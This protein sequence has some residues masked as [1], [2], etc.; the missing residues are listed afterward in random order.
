M[1]RR[2]VDV[3]AG[4]VL[5][6]FGIAF[7]DAGGRHIIRS[8]FE[9][10]YIPPALN[11]EKMA[12][13]SKFVKLVEAYPEY[14]EVFLNSWGTFRY[15]PV[16]LSPDTSDSSMGFERKKYSSAY[17][18]DISRGFKQV[19]CVRAEKYGSY[20]VFI[21]KRNYILP[22]SPGVLYSLD[23]RNPNEIDDEFLNNK[24]PFELIKDRWYMSKQLVT[25]PYRK[26][27]SNP[28]LPKS[29]IDHSLREPGPLD[30]EDR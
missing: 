11:K 1:V 4:I 24:K 8:V 30:R 25:S 23:G 17:T 15:D 19:G 10:V 22:T 2:T 9:H 7:F 6:L 16:E 27:D 29:L 14:N 13:Y 26:I 3:I 12:V 5:L 18:Y 28:P 21:P 20:V